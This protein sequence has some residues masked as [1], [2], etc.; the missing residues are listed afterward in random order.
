MAAMAIV[1]LTAA[2]SAAADIP[3]DFRSGNLDGW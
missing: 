3:R 1:I 2:Q